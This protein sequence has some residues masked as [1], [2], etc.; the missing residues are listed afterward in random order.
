MDH[1][2]SSGIHTYGSSPRNHLPEVHLPTT[3]LALLSPH[4]PL[5]DPPVS[6]IL[7]TTD[8]CCFAAEFVTEQR[9]VTA[10]II[11]K[12]YVAT[13]GLEVMLRIKMSRFK[14]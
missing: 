4:T 14:K 5:A 10:E 9:I 8:C 1:L 11:D 7:L 2:F 3:L 12:S 6:L 13:T